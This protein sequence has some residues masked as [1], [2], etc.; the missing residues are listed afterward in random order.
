MNS[1]D[2][3]GMNFTGERYV[4][5]VE[6]NIE[7]EHRHR[8][9][10]AREL[11]RGKDV[12]DLA[13]G[14]G[15]GSA[16][17]SSIANSVVGVD[18]ARDAVKHS[19][20]TY[21]QKNLRFMVSSCAEIPLPDAS[22]DVVVSFETLEHHDQHE[23]MMAEVKRV[24]RPDGL[25]IISTPDKYRYSVEPGYKNEFHVKEL[26]RHEFEG[27]LRKHFAIA[28]FYGQ[29]VAF[30]SLIIGKGPSV[31]LAKLPTESEDLA[32]GEEM[33]DPIYWIGLASDAALPLIGSSFLE[34][35]IER[36][37]TVLAYAGALGQQ[38]IKLSALQQSLS[39]RTSEIDMLKQA[40]AARV[41]ELAS[42][43]QRLLEGASEIDTLRQALAAQTR[44]IEELANRDALL[45]QILASH[46][47][48]MTRPFRVL[49]RLLRG[50]WPL[51]LAKLQPAVRKV[52]SLF[53]T[54]HALFRAAP[55]AIA[56][57]GSPAKALVGAVRVL[58][59][60]GLA[61]IKLRA[62]IL[63]EGEARHLIS[64]VDCDAQFDLYEKFTDTGSAPKISVIVPNFNHKEF[65]RQRLESVYNQTYKNIEVILLDDCSTD[66]SRLV[67]DE[68]AARY[69]EIT[70]CHF[71]KAN[72]GGVFKQWKKGLELATGDLVWIAES[73]DYC[74]ANLLEELI[75]PFSN[76]AVMLAF[77]RTDF[78]RG[79]PPLRLWTIEDYL[80]DLRLNC[81]TRP[82]IKSAHWLVNNVWATK[83]II[84]NVSS[85]VFRH[86][87]NLA[88]LDDQAW[89]ELTMCGDWIFYLTIARGGL[90]AYSPKATNFYR[91]HSRNISVNTQ[92]EDTYY[93]EHEVVG[94]H[95]VSL[96]RLNPG[97]LERQR[98]QLCQHWL[99]S[100]GKS[101]ADN[102]AA[103]YDL[104]RIAAAAKRRKFNVIMAAYALVA[105]GGEV[106]PITLAN[107]LKARGFAVT[108]L[109]CN[110]QATDP[111]I[112][113]M[114]DRSI[115]MLQLD[116]PTSIAAVF[117][118]LGAELVHSHHAWVD[119]TLSTL[120]ANSPGISHVVTM[121]GMYEMMQPDHLKNLLPIL[122]RRIDSFVYTAKKNL[123]PFPA[124]LR[125]QKEFIRIDNALAVTQ[126]NPIPRDELGIR[127]DDFVLCL[128]AR[129]I[130]EKGWEEAINAVII[131]NAKSK[132]GIHLLLIGEGAEY[133]RLRPKFTFDFIH[134]L[135]F[136]ANIRDYFATADLGFLPSRFPGES[137]PL[138]L[139]DCLHAGRPM[140]ASNIGEIAHMLA[141]REGLAGGLFD[142]EDWTIPVE[143]VAEL[144]VRSLEE[145]GYYQS[146]LARVPNAAAK[147]DPHVMVNAY[148][149]VY[150]HCRT[151]RSA[152]SG[153]RL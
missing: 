25:L 129:A 87:G 37:E 153:D 18:I 128:V 65:L 138:V 140:L 27:L 85:A 21:L 101:A 144:I 130:P 70:K 134:F 6:G 124:F 11:C 14:E 142:L 145:G 89:T 7:L 76:Q 109:N 149:T 147:F 81:W 139:I 24:L 43:R 116:T 75:K 53:R 79:D 104:D 42:M 146:M 103:L 105:G 4:P 68:Y 46:S 151:R 77:S 8:Y 5:S 106:F 58:L 97:V 66:E 62:A 23:E 12:L 40:L 17:L 1:E 84:P 110:Q 88:L 61:G 132:R 19:Q 90:V 150:Q 94:K 74:T 86:P 44:K 67:L 102:F 3:G 118:D 100:R 33:T 64:E 60:D 35:A 136:R 26:F 9:L 50:E 45:S 30:G 119:I 131:A 123:Q 98:I 115:P 111:G 95:L 10:F 117:N 91:Q 59:R 133:D 41:D 34:Q 143:K 63:V 39:E 54:T 137:F 93:R 82:F 126:I 56:Y 112:R 15:Y 55:R 72:S 22:I 71:N 78:V 52:Q 83:N 96:Y 13:S 38:E 108:F 125:H 32:C 135:G 107:M 16:M 36:S 51:V 57:Y 113:R 28:S 121:H 2:F 48:R 120:L 148:E 47:W 127:P 92:K 122:E 141:A 99:A 80:A 31:K 20:Q 69:P 73:D 29:R 49:R 152:N 114:L